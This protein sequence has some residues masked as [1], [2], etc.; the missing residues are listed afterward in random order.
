MKKD[1]TIATLETESP[2]SL[3]TKS[4]DEKPAAPATADYK[5]IRNREVDAAA[6]ELAKKRLLPRPP[7]K[8]ITFEEMQEYFK[9]LTPEMWHHIVLYIYRD[10]PR[11]LRKL[12]NPE[13]PKY[14]DCLSQPFDIEYMIEHH[15][16]GKYNV[17]AVDTEAKFQSESNKLF[18]CDFEVN[19]S[20]YE[21]KLNYEELDINDKGN[22]AY[23]QLL[24]HRGILDNRGQIMAGQP[25]SQ[26]GGNAD[27]VRQVLEFASKMN[28]DQQAA[29]RAKIDPNEES[30]SKSV[31]QILLEKMKQD[32]PAKNL[33]SLVAMIKDVMASNKVPDAT[34]QLEG[35]LKVIKEVLASSK[36][37]DGSTQLLE[38][39]MQMQNEHNKT[40]LQ[41]FEKLTTAR[42][43]APNPQIEQFEQ[44]IGFAERLSGFRGAAG[45]RSGWDV[46]LDYAKEIGVPL[47][48]TIG[49]LVSLRMNGR[50]MPGGIPMPPISTP[51]PTAAFDPYANPAAR[52]ALAA[53]LRQPAAPVTA[54]P[55][56]Q[57]EPP[58]NELAALIQM[59]GGLL[60]SHLNQGTPGYAFADN[61]TAL[62]GNGMHA[63]IVAQGE[64][65]LVQVLLSTPETAMFGET[66]LRNFVHEFI[67][68]QE[69]LDA[70]EN[71]E[72]NSDTP[73]S[74]ATGPYVDIDTTNVYRPP[75]ARGTR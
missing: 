52:N 21:P 3:D 64:P 47:L 70:E 73:D 16:G 42:T 14:I 50:G 61:I 57:P 30:L 41:L 22:M 51:A 45:R 54:A 9:L 62:L 6:A 15:G 71:Q 39:V 43:E 69:F 19:M 74:Q 7:G 35:L 63:Q 31:G 2:E 38:K 49:N 66:R 48:Q 4:K 55:T 28:A 1:E 29:L 5:I 23:V 36:P 26:G 8:K 17:M 68:F 75:A 18:D 67:H 44:M 53:Q 46:G 10:K 20:K 11:I 40:V 37:P 32:D 33:S 27:V 59:Y 56:P 24:Q 34:A 12:K 60:V 65:A 25:N 13:N 72:E 58:A